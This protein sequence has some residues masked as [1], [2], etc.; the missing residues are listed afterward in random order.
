MVAILHSPFW[1]QR[2]PKIPKR[3]ASYILDPENFSIL[4]RTKHT[5]KKK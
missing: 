1:P 2:A 3:A 5:H 4:D